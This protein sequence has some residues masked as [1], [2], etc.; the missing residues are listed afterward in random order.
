[1]VHLFLFFGGGGVNR[2]IYHLFLVF[3]CWCVSLFLFV[4][5][6]CCSSSL[7]FPYF[8]FSLVLFFLPYLLGYVAFCVF[9]FE[10]KGGQIKKKGQQQKEE[11]KK[12][13]KR[14]RKDPP[15]KQRRNFGKRLF[16]LF[17][18][19]CLSETSSPKRCK[20][21]EKTRFSLVLSHSL[22]N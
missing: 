19:C 2:M 8:L 3:I 16:V 20:N 18:F 13:K 1:M 15:P 5:V 9:L 10:V 14:K 22:K 12:D 7:C 4:V 11:I 21:T 6:L 17:L